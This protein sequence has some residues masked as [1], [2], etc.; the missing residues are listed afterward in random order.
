MT[1]GVGLVTECQGAHLWKVLPGIFRS[2]GL[3]KLEMTFK[4]I[5]IFNFP[6]APKVIVSQDEEYL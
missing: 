6:F 3:E 2:E 4:V 1:E 5:L